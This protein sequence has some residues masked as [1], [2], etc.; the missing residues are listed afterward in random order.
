MPG[1]LRR[2]SFSCRPQWGYP[3][4]SSTWWFVSLRPCSRAGG[5]LKYVSIAPQSGRCPRA[6][7]SS[8]ARSAGRT[9]PGKSPCVPTAV[10][11]EDAQRRSGAS[12]PAHSH[13]SVLTRR[14]SRSATERVREALVL[15]ASRRD[16][17][18]SSSVERP[19]PRRWDSFRR[20]ATIPD[21]SFAALGRPGL[22]PPTAQP[23]PARP[24]PAGRRSGHLGAA[25]RR[26]CGRE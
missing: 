15:Q 24:S 6:T 22:V 3:S 11:R 5:S 8:S 1:V 25:A 12:G 19:A 14:A 21:P 13:L 23:P 26:P 9:A 20:S 18:T 17:V 16:A 2:W 10:R 7:S 4:R